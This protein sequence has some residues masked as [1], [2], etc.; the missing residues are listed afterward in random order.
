MDESTVP[1]PPKAKL[2]SLATSVQPVKRKKKVTSRVE[3]D[4]SDDD[5]QSA[6]A[7]Q[8][9][10][11]AMPPAVEP[12]QPASRQ[13]IPLLDEIVPVTA[14]DGTT[15]LL[16]MPQH[17]LVRMLRHVLVRM[18]WCMLVWMVRLASVRAPVCAGAHGLCVLVRMVLHVLVRIVVRVL[19]RCKDG[20]LLQCAF[21]P[22]NSALV[23]AAYSP[24]GS[25][26]V[27]GAADGCVFFIAISRG[28]YVPIGFMPPPPGSGK[29]QIKPGVTTL[30]WAAEDAVYVGYTDGTFAE[31][32]LPT[33]V[34][35]HDRHIFHMLSPL[36]PSLSLQELLLFCFT[37][38]Y[39]RDL[40]I[41]L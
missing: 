8:S 35:A 18:I 29:D 40:R 9:I 4:E 25:F 12:I 2:G 41:A 15:P 14:S 21:K 5:D 33:E 10:N 37:G 3:K 32:V 20:L 11:P 36:L 38:G 39:F 1:T 17:V 13:P 22:H 7:D 28:S 30:T 34:F 16:C 24:D 6:V 27:T 31:L 23:S 19:V 26:L